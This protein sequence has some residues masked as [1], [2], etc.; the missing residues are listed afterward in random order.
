MCPKTEKHTLAKIR[1]LL[2]AVLV[3]EPKNSKRMLVTGGRQVKA[4]QDVVQKFRGGT[5][6]PPAAV[7]RAP[8]EGA[9]GLFSTTLLEHSATLRD[10]LCKVFRAA[11]C[12]CLMQ[13]GYIETWVCGVYLCAH[14]SDNLQPYEGVAICS[15]TNHFTRQQLRHRQVHAN[16]NH[17]G[18][19][20]MDSARD[21]SRNPG[22]GSY[23]P[24]DHA[25]KTLIASWPICCAFNDSNGRSA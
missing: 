11:L 18:V 24:S 1:G 14:G 12:R 16:T 13:E 3:S 19:L 10:R 2:S 25:T 21:T 7:Q 4:P 8:C 9:R 6:Q 23:C 15:V 5:R 20:H 22:N 17:R